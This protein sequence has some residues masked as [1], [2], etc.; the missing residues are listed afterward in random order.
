MRVSLCVFVCVHGTNVFGLCFGLFDPLFVFDGL[1]HAAFFRWACETKHR[2]RSQRRTPSWPW[3]CDAA[4]N[5]TRCM[6]EMN[7]IM[8]LG[9][10]ECRCCER[11][12]VV[13]VSSVALATR[14]SSACHVRSTHTTN[15]RQLL[16][17]RIAS[18]V[19]DILRPCAKSNF[20]I[21]TIICDVSPFPF[22]SFCCEAPSGHRHVSI[23]W[24]QW[25]WPCYAMSV[26]AY[27][28]QHCHA[29]CRAR[30]LWAWISPKA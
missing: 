12:R 30:F 6:C 28:G 5:Q 14:M 8:M 26:R 29:E 9:S 22:S 16:S 19:V 4:A 24:C 10:R 20:F 13:T 18:V 11:V 23:R 3:P 1:H 21:F 27:K 17:Q 25:Y 7:G 15:A 2:W